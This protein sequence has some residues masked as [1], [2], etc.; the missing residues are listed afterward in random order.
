MSQ[1]IMYVVLSLDTGGAERIVYNLVTGINKDLFT[2]IVCCLDYLGH[3]GEKLKEKGINIFA[4]NRKKGIDFHLIA[5]LTKLMRKYK[6][7]IMH[8]HSYSP[9][10]YGATSAILTKVPTIIFTEHGRFF[11]DRKRFKRIIYN[12]FLSLFTTQFVAVSEEIKRSLVTYEGIREKKIAIILNGVDLDKFNIDIPLEKKKKEFNLKS[13]DKILGLV[14]RLEIRKD[15]PTLL[16]AMTNVLKVFPET[17]LLIVGDGN[18]QTNLEDL[19]KEL[20]IYKNVVFCGRREDIPEIMKIIDIYVLSSISEGTSVSLLEA[21]AAKKPVVA[22]NVGGNPKVIQD[23]ISGILVPPQNPEILAEKII[24]LLGNPEKCM[25]MG[26]EGYKRVKE[27][28]SLQRMVS[29][30][31]ML[32]KNSSWLN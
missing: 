20:E 8:A 11:P 29:D 31:E 12:Q 24:S 17:K 28:F 5:R 27:K 1:N 23:G 9:Y 2:P 18:L 21:M 3:L 25:K 22:T 10:F 30:Y 15:I 19:S 6:V 16:K 7:S 26:E 32:Y 13:T 14:A 4:M